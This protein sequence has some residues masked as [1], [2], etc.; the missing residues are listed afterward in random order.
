M[1][2]VIARNPPWK[3]ER[4]SYKFLVMLIGPFTRRLSVALLV[5]LVACDNPTAVVPDFAY[6]PTGLTGGV[7]YRW[8]T[9]TRVRVFVEAVGTSGVPSGVSLSLAVQ[10]GATAWIR[11]PQ[12]REVTVDIVSNRDVADV[13]VFDRSVALPVVSGSCPFNPSGAAGY[14]YFC[15]ANGRAE[16]LRPVGSN[17]A[18]T[19]LVIR[20]DMSTTLSQ[21][22]LDALVGHEM[23]HAL[24]IGGH[25][26]DTADL[27]YTRP[28]ATSPTARDRQTLRNVLGR[29]PDLT[30]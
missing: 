16:R 4:T 10:R 27:M 23:G 28:T 11:V 20:V 19:A 12:D 9:G 13:I 30:L 7:L 21:P 8:S 6:D 15:E 14:T 25:S 26:P 24:G 17:T 3:I 1:T 5:V 22:E 18:T 29:S 2:S